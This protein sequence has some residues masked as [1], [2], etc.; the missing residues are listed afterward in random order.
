MSVV[1]E[2]C[3]HKQKHVGD[4]CENCKEP[5]VHHEK[6]VICTECG[7][8]NDGLAKS[9]IG[10][11]AILKHTANLEFEK[12]TKIEDLN[13]KSLFLNLINKIKTIPNKYLLV[14]TASIVTVFSLVLLFFLVFNKSY[15]IEA[16]EGFYY[17]SN[18]NEL[19]L[20]DE[21]QD[22]I[23]L[24]TDVEE[25]QSVKK[26][27]KYIYFLADNDLYQYDKKAQLLAEDVHSFK[28][29]L[30]GDQVLY[31]VF[32]PETGF[33]DLY[34]YDGKDHMRLDGNVGHS[35]YIFSDQKKGVYYVKDITEEESLG[36]LYYKFDKDP[37]KAIA[38]DVYEPLVSLDKDTVYFVRKDVHAVTKFELYYHN[39]EQII[40]L[41]RHIKHMLV[42]PEEKI[43]YLVQEKNDVIS[44][45]ST[46]EGQ[47]SQVHKGI[48]AYGRKTYGDL[49]EPVVYLDPF[50][51]F[52]TETSQIHYYLDHKD[53]RTMEVSF[54]NYILSEDGKLI[55]TMSDQS[56]DVYDFNKGKISN[57][58]NLGSDADLLG[59]SPEGKYG[60]IRKHQ[61]DLVLS[62][63]G[64]EID[65]DPKGQGFQ[66]SAD[67]KY[68]LYKADQELFAH[69]ITAKEPVFLSELAETY[70]MIDKYVYYFEGNKVYQYRLGKFKS[71]EQIDTVKTWNYLE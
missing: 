44:I 6:L 30:K 58:Y 3:H 18:N 64:D 8:S 1:C 21:D 37:P 62:D 56:I 13:N 33:G 25:V 71:K 42:H 67:E 9:C 4:T 17:L 7:L 48:L 66:F 12:D 27:K 41:D 47:V 19:Y 51:F 68:L 61:G 49:Q 69:K 40:E 70:F 45:L 60:I 22:K 24:K 31:T 35:R 43:A 15:Y 63:Q 29:N 36:T 39:G 54:D 11:G 32:V 34:H 2:K 65:T 14:A 38:D 20:I 57:K 53:K 23:L 10:C 55:Y 16:E 28:V 46:E 26:F 52:Y 59:V 5:L 50:F